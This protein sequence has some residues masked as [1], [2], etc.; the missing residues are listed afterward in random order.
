MFAAVSSILVRGQSGTDAQQAVVS[1]I[2]QQEGFLVCLLFGENKFFFS[3][4]LQTERSSYKLF[5]LGTL[6]IWL[7]QVSYLLV[8]FF[9]CA[10]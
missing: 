7:P 5:P 10:G 2:L 3:H 6:L 4:Y 9:L 8:V 1:F